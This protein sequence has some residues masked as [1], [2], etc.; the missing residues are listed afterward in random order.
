MVEPKI[1]SERKGFGKEVLRTPYG[2]WY[3]QEA[4]QT[5]DYFPHGTNRPR[6]QESLRV[7]EN[8]LDGAIDFACKRE[9]KGA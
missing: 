8:N 3:W 7:R 2:K 9:L 4:L 1:Q 6:I 5:I